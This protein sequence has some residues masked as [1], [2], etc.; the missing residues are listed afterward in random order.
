MTFMN[1]ISIWMIF[2]STIYTKYF[3]SELSTLFCCCW[4]GFFKKLLDFSLQKFFKPA[5]FSSVKMNKT[6]NYQKWS[7][8]CYVMKIIIRGRLYIY[9]IPLNNIFIPCC[10]IQFYIH[11]QCEAFITS[12]SK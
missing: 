9:F 8:V 12:T 3:H 2:T 1:F 6:L 7:A 11:V 5:F 10:L 4:C